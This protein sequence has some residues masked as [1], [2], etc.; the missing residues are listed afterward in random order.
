MQFINLEQE[1][2][3]RWNLVET[4]QSEINP[5]LLDKNDP[6][7][8]LIYVENQQSLR[9]DITSV[10]DALNGYQKENVFIVSDISIQ[11]G[12][13]KFVMLTTSYPTN[14]KKNIWYKGLI[15]MEY[16]T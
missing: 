4:M 1:V 12:D 5:S 16:G 14:T 7:K 13:Y 3:A 8:G 11:R 10:K 2:E 9:K 15:W 6:N